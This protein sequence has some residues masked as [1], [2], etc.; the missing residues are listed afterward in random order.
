MSSSED[1]AVL[2]WD[3]YQQLAAEFPHLVEQMIET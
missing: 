1:I 2:A 3:E